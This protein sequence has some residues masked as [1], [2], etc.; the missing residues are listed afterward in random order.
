MLA[1]RREVRL[2]VGGFRGDL[3]LNR[4]AP[5]PDTR[6]R[7]D[8]PR[9]GRKQEV[10]LRPYIEGLLCQKCRD[11]WG[12]WNKTDGG[13]DLASVSS[14]VEVTYNPLN[15]CPRLQLNVALLRRDQAALRSGES[16][17]FCPDIRWRGKDICKN[18]FE[19]F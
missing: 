12:D 2:K 4:A 19:R 18:L 15:L 16:L 8:D 10:D 3:T 6:W 7:C 17:I 11:W 9:H 1:R 13:L 14:F 5:F